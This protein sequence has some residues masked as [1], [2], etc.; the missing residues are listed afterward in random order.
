[1]FK[2]K[3]NAKTDGRKD[4]WAVELKLLVTSIV[5]MYHYFFLLP[6]GSKCPWARHF[7]APA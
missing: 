2:E 3:G 6:C 7:K 1:M 5:Y 4:A